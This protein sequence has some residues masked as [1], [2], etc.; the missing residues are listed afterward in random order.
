VPGR[1]RPNQPSREHFD[2]ATVLYDWFANSRGEKLPTFVTPP[3]HTTG[4]VSVIFFVGWLSCDSMEY[5][6]LGTHDGFGILLRRRIHESGYAT[7][8]MDKP[9]AGESQGECAKADSESQIT[10]WPAAFNGKAKYDLTDLDRVFVVGLCNRCGFSAMHPAIPRCAVSSP[11]APGAYMV[12]AQVGTERRRLRGA[13]KS[14]AEGNTA[15][16]AFADFYD[17]Y[18]YD[19]YLDEWDDSRAGCRA[20]SGVDEPLVRTPRRGATVVRLSFSSSYRG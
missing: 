16:K 13:R 10:G 4:K 1:H 11:V 15:V 14:A 6:D 5:P 2:H 20:A 9:G 7:V 19:L 12:R 17:L 8:R 18:F 3:N